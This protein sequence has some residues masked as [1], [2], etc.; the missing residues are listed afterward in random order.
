MKINDRIV[1]GAESFIR[2]PRQAQ[3]KHLLLGCPLIG[4]IIGLIAYTGTTLFSLI[5]GT[6]EQL[7]TI[8]LIPVALALFDRSGSRMREPVGDWTN[9]GLTRVFNFPWIPAR[10]RPAIDINWEPWRTTLV[11]SVL[12][13]TFPD[14]LS[15]IIHLPTTILW[16]M[17]TSAALGALI[18]FVRALLSKQTLRLV[19][20]QAGPQSTKS[21]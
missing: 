1:D 13:L 7:G 20:R 17:F 5:P 21:S 9:R 12:L 8:L 4:G 10:F 11:V 6:Y 18:S 2:N 14:S 19:F 16:Q 3:L 15:P